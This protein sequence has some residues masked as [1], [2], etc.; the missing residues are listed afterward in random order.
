MTVVVMPNK[1]AEYMTP[2]PIVEASREL[3]GGIDLDPASSQLANEVVQANVF[4]GWS[5]MPKSF[6][7]S[8]ADGLAL[9]WH[10]RVLLNPPGGMAATGS[11]SRSKSAV[12]WYR[13]AKHWVE[14]DVEQAVFVG[15]N[16]EILR[17]AQWLD[18][19]QP[20]DLPLCIP[21][22]RLH[23]DLPSEVDEQGRPTVGAKR[24]TRGQP[25]HPNCIIYLPPTS[26]VDTKAA[27]FAELFGQFG[28]VR[29]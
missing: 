12:W 16:L 6:A 19:P 23:F 13:L 2:A 15:F 27:Q 26:E 22:K 4:Y 10:G 28:G 7:K 17:S 29:L 18:C 3:M 11:V 9:P 20:L 21:N 14:G 1:S 8:F 5:R 24:I 25:T